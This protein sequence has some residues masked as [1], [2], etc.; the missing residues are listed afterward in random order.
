MLQRGVYFHTS[1]FYT[2]KHLYST[3][4]RES[5]TE[6]YRELRAGLSRTPTS[7]WIGSV[8]REIEEPEFIA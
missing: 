8:A 4:S 3:L 5:L 2:P 1:L 6:T 7:I